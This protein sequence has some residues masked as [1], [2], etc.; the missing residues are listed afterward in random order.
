MWVCAWWVAGYVGV[1]ISVCAVYRCVDLY[2]WVL[3][4][5]REYGNRAFHG[6]N[7]YPLPHFF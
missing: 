1:C 5:I 7:P 3:V 2:V 6:F 4:F